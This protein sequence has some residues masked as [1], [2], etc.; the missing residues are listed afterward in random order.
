MK[1]WTVLSLLALLAFSSAVSARQQPTS[2]DQRALRARLE[3][4]F[5][6]VPLTDGVALRPK[7]RMQD[8][9]LIEITDGSVLVNGVAV[10]GQELRDKLGSDATD[11]LRVSYLDASSRRALFA[12]ITPSAP[13]EAQPPLAGG[14][15][16]T[17][18]EDDSPLVVVV[19][20]AGHVA[21]GDARPSWFVSRA[22][23]PA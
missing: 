15:R 19:V 21:P 1:R 18:L 23:L 20:N 17:I 22:D 7:A 4:R 14:Q 2:D 6:V 13:V 11:V 10:T 3:Q 16:R 9:R 5:D 12:P 8:V